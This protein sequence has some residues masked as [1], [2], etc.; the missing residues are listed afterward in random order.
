VVIALLAI[1][2]WLYL[3]RGHSQQKAMDSVAVLPF[4]NAS[5]DPN[6]EY[7]VTGLLKA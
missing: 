5:N 1:G 2:G 7:L 3:L 6:T 4:V